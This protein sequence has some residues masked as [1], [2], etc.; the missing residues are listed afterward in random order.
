[1]VEELAFQAQRFQTAGVEFAM[2]VGGDALREAMNG[3]ARRLFASLAWMCRAVVCC[4]IFPCL[5]RAPT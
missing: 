1:M 4:R 5:P 2:V 3:E